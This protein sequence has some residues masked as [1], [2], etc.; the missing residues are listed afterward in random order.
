MA[1]PAKH[2]VSL[3]T[4]RV[5]MTVAE[6]FNQHKNLTGS[7]IEARKLA[8]RNELRTNNDA[9]LEEIERELAALD[10][11]IAHQA[12]KRTSGKGFNPLQNIGAES[13]DDSVYSTMEYRRA[14]YKNL[15]GLDLNDE[16]RA[17][18]NRGKANTGQAPSAPSATWPPLSRPKR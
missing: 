18:L 7:Q 14:F 13:R 9:N 17:A 5:T 4:E 15:K 1:R 2:G 16:E 8:I 10:E 3:K 12:E 11:V 6:Y